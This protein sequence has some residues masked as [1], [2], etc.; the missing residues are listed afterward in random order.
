MRLLLATSTYSTT[1]RLAIRV[2]GLAHFAY[3]PAYE[4]WNQTRGAIPVADSFPGDSSAF[5]VIG[6]SKGRRLNGGC[7]QKFDS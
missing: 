2:Y 6:H 4:K 1:T 5:Q 3:W 7:L